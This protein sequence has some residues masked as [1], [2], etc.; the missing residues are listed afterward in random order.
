VSDNILLIGYGNELRGDDAVGTII[1]GKIEDMH[2]PGVRTI[3]CH[4]LTPELAEDI[5][6][7]RT[8][9][10]VDA[11]VEVEG[12]TAQMVRAEPAPATRFHPHLGDPRALLSLAQT[13][14]K[15]SPVGWCLHVPARDFELGA[16]LSPVAEH[17]MASALEQLKS[18]LTPA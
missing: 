17:G 7:A 5:A 6:G 15:K 13:L 8:V 12:D 4:Q 11:S 3:A 16:A 9:I 2:L 1:A 18:I 14:Y 10:F